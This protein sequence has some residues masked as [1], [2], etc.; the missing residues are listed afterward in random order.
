MRALAL[1]AAAALA[2]AGCGQ[3]TVLAP[4]EVQV[5][6]VVDGDTIRITEGGDVVTV[7]IIG[8][9]TPET[10]DPDL[11]RD[12]N[13]KL[14]PEC[15]AVAA[16][17][18]ATATLSGQQVVLRPDVSQDAED[19]YGRRLAYVKVNGEDYGLLA[20]TAGHAAE[21][22]YRSSRPYRMQDVYREA[23]RKAKKTGRGLWGH[24]DDEHDPTEGKGR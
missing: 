11:P 22:T 9:D 18:F 23:E 2:L 4:N 21:Y 14:V 13:G 7:R 15:G 19:R 3:E 12:R 5:V 1:A 24:C 16:S 10:K 17:N 6:K 8:L 20:L